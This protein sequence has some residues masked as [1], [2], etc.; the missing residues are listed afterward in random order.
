ME[1]LICLL[2][3]NTQQEHKYPM[4][5]RFDTVGVDQDP[6]DFVT[7]PVSPVSPVLPWVAHVDTIVLSADVLAASLHYTVAPPTSFKA[8]CVIVVPAKKRNRDDERDDAPTDGAAEKLH[9]AQLAPTGDA[10]V[11][12][13]ANEDNDVVDND[14]QLKV[15]DAVSVRMTGLSGWEHHMHCHVRGTILLV[16]LNG[17]LRVRLHGFDDDQKMVVVQSNRLQR[18]RDADVSREWRV[19][20]LVHVRIHEGGVDGWWEARISGP[21]TGAGWPVKWIGHDGG[22]TALARNIR[23]ASADE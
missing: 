5:E 9:R 21:R 10:A 23:R 3:K 13:T 19:E 6:G 20:E 22:A 17:K 16:C 1:A 11:V 2:A 14:R 8:N 7:Y 12:L 18:D 15:G 4:S